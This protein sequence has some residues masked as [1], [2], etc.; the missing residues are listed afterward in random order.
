M[1]SFGLVNVPIKL[2]A[3]THNHNV[4]LHQV[5]AL[6]GGRIRYQ[7]VCEL[8]GE[9]IAQRDIVSGYTDGHHQVTLT[10]EDLEDLPAERSREISVVEFVPTDQVD[11]IMF[12]D[13]YYL[14]PDS[15]SAKAYVLLR[16]VLTQTNRTAIVKY[17]LR[18]K[19]HLGI[20]RVKD[21]VLVL[22]SL[23]WADE[24]RKPDFPAL[25]NVKISDRELDMAKALVSSFE[26]DFDPHQYVDE[27]QDQ[28]RTLIEDKIAS[29]NGVTVT[30][31]FG[32][33]PKPDDGGEVTDLME[34]LRRSVAAAKAKTVPAKP[35][36]TNAAP[37]SEETEPEPEPSPK[38][39]VTKPKATAK[40]AAKT[41]TSAPK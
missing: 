29:G 2:Y 37:E 3:A 25:E 8:D 1:V 11:P 6:D 36:A 35:K 33:Q 13:S 28:L 40:T 16:E 14:E 7:K 26:S 20:L 41:K 17:A 39:R 12:G 15:K 22:Q 10:K 30:Q 24:V 34:A 32:K 9:V 38:K 27:Y 31:A 21:G 4:G 18:E 23:L 19:S 5:H